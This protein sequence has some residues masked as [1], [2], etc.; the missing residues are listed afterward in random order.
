MIPKILPVYDRTKIQFSHGYGAY[1]VTLEGDHYLDFASG[2]AVNALGHCHPQIVKALNEQASKLWHISNLY[3]IP[4]MYKLAELLVD[5]SFAD[6]VFFTN[7]GTE[8]VECAIKIVRKYNYNLGNYKRNH[9]IT[10]KGGYHGRTLAALSGSDRPSVME[11]FAPF[12]SGFCKVEFNDLQAVEEAITEETA[13]IMIEPIQGEGGIRVATNE[14]LKGL[15][16]LANKYKLI[17][18]FDEIQCGLGRTGKLFAYEHANIKPDI[19][20]ISKAMGNGFPVG[21]C[22]ATEEVA[23]CMTVGAHGSTFGGNPLAMAVG[24]AVVS[25]LRESELLKN[26]ADM[27]V[28]MQNQLKKLREKF[29]NIIE[30]VRG[31]GLMIGIKTHIPNTKVIEKLRKN[32][33]LTAPA[34]DNVIKVYPPLIVKEAE[35]N[36][37]IDVM[38]TSFA[39][40]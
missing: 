33:L 38:E 25:I 16:V 21:A 29:P 22:L 36:K 13:A 18:I 37:A 1:L 12:V 31:K 39:E 5:N 32:K 9:I 30:S 2:I 40:L 27:G 15:R 8:A 3:E 28:L 11:G 24:Y 34:G 7:S 6:T 4:E 35:I 19:M 14:F 10:F 17:L 20:T 26:V 23:S